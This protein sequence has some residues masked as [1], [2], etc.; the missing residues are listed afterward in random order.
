MNA[1]A[2]FAL[3]MTLGFFFWWI[4]ARACRERGGSRRLAV[5]FKATLIVL[6][7]S[8]LVCVL[9]LSVGP[10]ALASACRAVIGTLNL[11]APGI[12]GAA[13]AAVGMA[14][15]PRTTRGSDRH[16]A[17]VIAG[18]AA[19]VAC[20]FVAFEIGKAAHDA[21]MR[22][23]FLGSGYPVW[24]MYA[25]MAAEVVGA[26][27]LL[28]PR[29]RLFAACGLGLLMIGAIATHARNHDPFADS[30]DAVRMLILVTS[31][32]LLEKRTRSVTVPSRPAD[33]GG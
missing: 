15:Y 29:A 17:D 28:L 13:V 31:I 30:L 9:L 22:Q 8:G 10:R 27:G 16:L 32:A 26:V 5:V 23:F 4:L 21:E 33:A 25:V 3:A 19:Y 1:S 24:F 12:A 6:A 2:S 18:L 14:F 11:I 20:A 7:L